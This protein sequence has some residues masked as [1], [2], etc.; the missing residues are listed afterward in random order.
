MT[1]TTKSAIGNASCCLLFLCTG[2]GGKKCE[3]DVA[4]KFGL[5]RDELTKYLNEVGWFLSVLTPPGQG[6]DVPVVMGPICEPCAVV[7]MPE[8]VMAAKDQLRKKRGW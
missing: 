5:G 1:E 6:D 4:V 3:E 8:V 2:P 7:V